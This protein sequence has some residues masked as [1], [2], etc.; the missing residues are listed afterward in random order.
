MSVFQR[1]M[2]VL[3]T[4]IAVCA[5]WVTLTIALPNNDPRPAATG[6]QW[7]EPQWSDQP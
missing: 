1:A 3:V 7:V 2:L 5:V 4:V 6:S